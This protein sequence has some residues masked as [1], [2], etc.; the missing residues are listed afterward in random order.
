MRDTC[1]SLSPIFLNFKM[2]NVLTVLMNFCPAGE[3]VVITLLPTK[4]QSYLSE[5]QNQEY[6]AY[7]MWDI[8]F[9]IAFPIIINLLL[10]S[11]LL[12]IILEGGTGANH[13][14]LGAKI[15]NLAC[16][17]FRSKEI[18]W[19]SDPPPIS[20]YVYF[21]DQNRITIGPNIFFLK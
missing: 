12:S 14:L 8:I 3:N 10:V 4:N 6:K 9:G 2:I 15:W 1:S 11:I 20:N 21:T 16:G 7:P 17:K 13:V 18:F 5:K 19:H